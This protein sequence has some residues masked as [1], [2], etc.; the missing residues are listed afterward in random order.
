MSGAV[1]AVC[2]C[3]PVP[4]VPNSAQGVMTK[5]GWVAVMLTPFGAPAAFWPCCTSLL[6]DAPK[7]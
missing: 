7:G 1:A 5:A 3:N 4:F 6:Y 2:C